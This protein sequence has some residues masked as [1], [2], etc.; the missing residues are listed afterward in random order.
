MQ[1]GY[2]VNFVDNFKSFI[3]DKKEEFSLSFHGNSNSRDF[4]NVYDL[5][6]QS[7]RHGY[8]LNL[9]KIGGI[10]TTLKLYSPSELYNKNFN[11]DSIL[12]NF[13]FINHFLTAEKKGFIKKN[14]NVI[15]LKEEFFISLDD[16]SANEL[17]FGS[18]SKTGF[19]LDI[20]TFS[21]IEGKSTYNKM[22]TILENVNKMSV[23]VDHISNS[24]SQ[25]RSSGNDLGYYISSNPGRYHSSIG[26]K[27][28]DILVTRRNEI[29]NVPVIQ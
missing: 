1:T 5:E 25:R 16:G 2:S 23:N 27:G 6:E 9:K 4:L 29:D 7:S 19:L 8:L 21:M 13:N 28:I 26:I 17:L 11:T 15:E 3:K 24:Q 12:H 10:N 20:D 22:F 18:R 14:K